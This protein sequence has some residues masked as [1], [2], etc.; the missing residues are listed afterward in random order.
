MTAFA[1]VLLWLIENAVDSEALSKAGHLVKS[2]LD[3]GTLTAEEYG[4]LCE[5]GRKKR[6]EMVG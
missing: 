4:E 5:A 2:S 3:V 1:K 6:Q